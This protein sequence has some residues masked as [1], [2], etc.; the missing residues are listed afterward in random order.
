MQPAVESI[1]KVVDRLDTKSEVIND[2]NRIS[3]QVTV[4]QREM[5]LLNK[6]LFENELNKLK[7]ISQQLREESEQPAE[8]VYEHRKLT[9]KVAKLKNEVLELA[10]HRDEINIKV[11]RHLDGPTISQFELQ[12]SASIQRQAIDVLHEKLL[13]LQGEIAKSIL[14]CGAY[15]RKTPKVE[16][17]NT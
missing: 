11:N 6:N 12:Q 1:Q 17:D 5:N 2:D 3:A 7:I 9:E 15:I 4:I 8:Q 16:E 10:V 13:D 14:D